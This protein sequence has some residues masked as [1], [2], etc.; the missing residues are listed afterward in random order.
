MSVMRERPAI[1]PGSLLHK[2]FQSIELSG[3]TATRLGHLLLA[4]L[5]LGSTSRPVAAHAVLVES[6]PAPKSTTSG[7]SIAIR[8]RFNARID[9]GHSIIKLIRK[10]GSSSK[11]QTIK[12]PEPNTLT[13][14]AT[15][16]QTGDY[17]IRWQVLAPDGHITSGEIPFSV[18]GS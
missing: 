10:D 7:P 11:L 17:S 12:Q 5:I 13:A 9:A 15:G 1:P 14:T 3:Q 8:L 16:L 4:I 6:T 2:K 18:G